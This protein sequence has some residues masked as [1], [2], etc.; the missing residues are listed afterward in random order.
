MR[1]TVAWPTPGNW[2]D[3]EWFT[4]VNPPPN[5]DN[6]VVIVSPVA[7]V[8]I[9]DMAQADYVINRIRGADSRGVRDGASLP[10]TPQYKVIAINSLSTAYQALQTWLSLD[11]HLPFD[12]DLFLQRIRTRW[13]SNTTT[14]VAED[15]KI[16]EDRFPLTWQ[17]DALVTLGNSRPR[18]ILLITEGGARSTRRRALRRALRELYPDAVDKD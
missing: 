15:E 18:D 12:T 16:H 2:R 8:S 5:P 4:W 7:G 3:F 9:L 11:W 1:A 6:W 13:L 14:Q 17:E 10:P